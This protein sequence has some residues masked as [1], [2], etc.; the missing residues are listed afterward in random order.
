LD[1][2]IAKMQDEGA[3]LSRNSVSKLSGVSRKEIGRLREGPNVETPLRDL[4]APASELLSNWALNPDYCDSGGNPAVIPINGAIGSLE[5]LY[6][7]KDSGHTFE[8]VFDELFQTS[9]VEIVEETKVRMLNRAC[10]Q[11]GDTKSAIYHFE[12]T[13]FTVGMTLVQ[14]ITN[15][16]NE[17]K[18]LERAAF[19]YGLRP[20][21]LPRFLL[22]TKSASES[23]V[24]LVDE[25]ISMNEDKSRRLSG[26]HI[27]G[28]GVYAF[29]V[30]DDHILFEKSRI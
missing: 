30:R 2:A 14:N 7:E 4:R 11:L 25:W 15:E 16:E 17:S 27:T 20:L 8:S 29:H 26:E 3:A 23:F 22:L 10:I 6:R 24:E 1:A 28:V 18:L 12:R 9:S 13:L 5:S 21:S 19:T